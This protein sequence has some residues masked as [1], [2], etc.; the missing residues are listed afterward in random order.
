MK[1]LGSFLLIGLSLLLLV[2]LSYSAGLA[3]ATAEQM[4]THLILEEKHRQ[5]VHE[6]YL[7][8]LGI[9]REHEDKLNK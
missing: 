6:E 9:L 1:N 4:K 8:I 3:L 5:T 2:I 7:E